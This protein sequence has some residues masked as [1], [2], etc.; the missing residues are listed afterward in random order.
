M[1]EAVNATMQQLSD[2]LRR[3]VK[4]KARQQAAKRMA[5]REEDKDERSGE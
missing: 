2:A 4:D 1:S 3:M 5:E